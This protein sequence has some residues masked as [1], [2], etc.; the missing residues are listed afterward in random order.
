M[1]ERRAINESLKDF[2]GFG[3][4]SRSPSMHG[5]LVQTPGKCAR[6]WTNGGKEEKRR[7][8]ER[9]VSSVRPRQKTRRDVEYSR[10]SIIPQIPNR[11]ILQHVQILPPEPT[12]LPTI[13]PAQHLRRISSASNLPPEIH[14]GLVVDVHPLDRIRIHRRPPEELVGRGSEEFE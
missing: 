4:E 5:D 3:F 10:R 13:P 7:K 1:R 6:W 2:V 11:H 14:L 8:K 12:P 9:K